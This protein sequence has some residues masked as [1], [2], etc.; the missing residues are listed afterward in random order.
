[1]ICMWRGDRWPKVAVLG[2][3]RAAARM[4]KKSDRY[5][6]CLRSVVLTDLFRPKRKV[7]F[8]FDVV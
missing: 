4:C 3:R 1:M 6:G 5:T 2:M 8:Y 7:N